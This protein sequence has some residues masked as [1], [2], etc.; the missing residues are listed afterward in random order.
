MSDEVHP[1]VSIL[2]L[3]CEGHR[4][5]YVAAIV[6]AAATGGARTKLLT[7]PRVSTS[8]EFG[9]HLASLVADGRLEVAELSDLASVAG[10][11]RTLRQLRSEG[12]FLVVPDSDRLLP[13]VLLAKVLRRSPRALSLVVMRPPMFDRRRARTYLIAPSKVLLLTVLTVFRR[14]VRVHL[15]DDPLAG[16]SERV[17]RPPLSKLGA[18]LND[19]MDLMGGEC[20]TPMEIANLPTDAKVVAVIG[21]LDER[22]RLPLILDAWLDGGWQPEGVLVLAGKVPP[23]SKRM[24][25]ARLVQLESAVLI[26]RYLSNSEIMGVLTRAQAVLVLYDGGLS[27]GVLLSAAA[28][29]RWVVCEAGSRTGRVALGNRIAV[30]CSLDPRS[31]AGAMRWVLGAARTPNPIRIAASDQFAAQVLVGARLFEPAA[32]G[33]AATGTQC[34]SVLGGHAGLSEL[35]LIAQDRLDSS[36]INM[37]TTGSA[38]RAQSVADAE[39]GLEPSA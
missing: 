10:R 9:T 5:A 34:D 22:K 2:Q 3:G 29:G 31:I 36:S 4:L 11:L 25:E 7:V 32:V 35:R 39:S 13:T 33:G 24:L 12:S 37:S 30:E 23:H 18:R 19:P 16:E 1:V 15:L 26:D 14:S 27:S 17:W 6:R 28:A 8:D 21:S 20:R 38:H